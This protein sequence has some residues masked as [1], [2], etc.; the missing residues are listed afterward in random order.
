MRFLLSA[1]IDTNEKPGGIAA[2][3]GLRGFASIV[4]LASHAGAFGLAGQGGPA[5]LLFFILSGFVLALP[6][7]ESPSRIFEAFEMPRF[8]FNR[9]LRIMPALLTCVIWIAWLI[10]PPSGWIFRILTFQ[11]T[12]N[13]LWSV[14][15]EVRFYLFFPI[16][17][18]T[19]A[20]LP[21]RASRVVM[22]LAMIYAAWMV[23]FWWRIEAGSDG[24]YPFLIWLFF[25]GILL[26]LFAPAYSFVARSRAATFISGAV[27]TGVL[28]SIFLATEQTTADFWRPRFSWLYSF[29]GAWPEERWGLPFVVMLFCIIAAPGAI[30]SR[31]LRSWPMRH[32]G[33][34]SYG[35]YLYH[36]PAMA[37][38]APFGWEK[39]ELCFWLLI[40]TYVVS[41]L[42]Y[43]IIERPFLTL[44]LSRSP[45]LN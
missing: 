4:V 23:Q 33:L 25:S 5:V 19:L 14:T 7:A 18:G 36:V 17:I 21:N 26:S 37:V 30:V 32:L 27:A 44:K 16:V 20:L 42:S 35:L 1:F 29:N 41:L 10:T 11:E 3:H 15:E 13:H 6:F 12:W 31:L 45:R 34:L 40:V 22:M 8:F 39:T 38:L 24:S 9:A 28:L 43:T 2:L